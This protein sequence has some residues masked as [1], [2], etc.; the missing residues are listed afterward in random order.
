VRRPHAVAQPSAPTPSASHFAD[1]GGSPPRCLGARICT[2]TF[3]ETLQ[4]NSALLPVPAQ[5]LPPAH[6]EARPAFAHLLHPAG[7]NHAA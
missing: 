7:V 5:R 1:P 3:L 6:G 4:P 2:P